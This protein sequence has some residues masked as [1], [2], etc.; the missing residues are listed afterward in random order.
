MYMYASIV[1]RIIACMGNSIQLGSIQVSNQNVQL[2]HKS[3]N[4]IQLI[5]SDLICIYFIRS[6][7]TGEYSGDIVV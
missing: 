4:R 3:D 7:R 6:L 1:C 5:G 2:R